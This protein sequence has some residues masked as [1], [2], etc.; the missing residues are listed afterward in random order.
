MKYSTP[1]VTIDLEE[2]QELQTYRDF[3][4]NAREVAFSM[5]TQQEIIDITDPC[6]YRL[7]AFNDTYQSPIGMIK[8]RDEKIR[9]QVLQNWELNFIQKEKK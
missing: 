8:F 9:Q 1:K 4:L 2:Y 5:M 6:V 7:N 3:K